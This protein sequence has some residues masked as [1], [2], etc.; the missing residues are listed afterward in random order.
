M[1]ALTDKIRRLVETRGANDDVEAL[2]RAWKSTTFADESA[3]IAARNAYEGSDRTI[4]IDDDA[5]TS[6]SYEGL[7][8]QAWVWIPIT[9]GV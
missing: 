4:E 3:L 2:V 9:E 6:E 8:V 5:M 7:W 1:S